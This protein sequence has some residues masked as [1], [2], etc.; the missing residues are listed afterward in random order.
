M[1]WYLLAAATA[2]IATQCALCRSPLPP[3]LWPALVLMLVG[4]GAV[5]VSKAR[6]G[7]A[8]APQAGRAAA[9]AGSTG[10]MH[11][12]GGSW[13]LAWGPLPADK[14][15]QRGQGTPRDLS[16]LL[17]GSTSGE[18]CIPAGRCLLFADMAADIQPVTDTGMLAAPEMPVS[19]PFHNCHSKPLSQRCLHSL[20]PP[21]AV[22][23][24]GGTAWAWDW[25]LLERFAW[26]ASCFW[27]RQAQ[28][29]AAGCC[30]VHAAQ[31][32]T[33]RVGQ[34]RQGRGATVQVGQEQ[35]PSTLSSG[36]P[37]L[38]TEHR[39]ACL[40]CRGPTGS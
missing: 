10:S 37:S 25:P 19:P 23:L 6:A 5:I 22:C 21:Q 27:S 13:M 8:A 29:G 9:G 17:V 28:R 39:H 34:G 24:R 40:L 18:F 7:A 4:A 20:L 26:Q 36:E 1:T 31:Q 32:F 33:G 30:S 11:I 14:A 2:Y 12:A 38:P 3:G 35:S 15:V 16:W